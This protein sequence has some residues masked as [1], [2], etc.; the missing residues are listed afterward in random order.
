MTLP[1]LD[2]RELD[3]IL[4][5]LAVTTPVGGGSAIFTL[6]R[7]LCAQTGQTSSEATEARMC[8]TFLQNAIDAGVC[9]R[10]N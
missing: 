6:Y 2:P 8:D 7:K 1:E 5:A 10:T 3:L 9:V 4:S